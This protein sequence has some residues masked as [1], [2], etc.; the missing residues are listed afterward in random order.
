MQIEIHTIVINKSNLFWEIFPFIAALTV[1]IYI[2]RF[3]LEGDALFYFLS[4][5]SQSLAAI[6]TLLF[7]IT[8]FGAQ[9]TGNLTILDKIIDSKTKKLMIIF[10]I[11]ILMPLIQLG[12]DLNIVYFTNAENLSLTI[13][14][15]IATFCIFAIIPFIEDS[16]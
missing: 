4:A 16:R 12:T 9:M 15:I 7:A 5:I 13:D 6:F 14:L 2:N 11:G 3:T 10:A 1:G 8:I